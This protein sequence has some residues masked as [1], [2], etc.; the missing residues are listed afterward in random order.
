MSPSRE[1]ACC[2]PYQPFVKKQFLQKKISPFALN[3]ERRNFADVI[4][5]KTA[6]TKGKKVK[7]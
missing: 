6:T 5:A 7:S 3:F 4:Y 1:K 2:S